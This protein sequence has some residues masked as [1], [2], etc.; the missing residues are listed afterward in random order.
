MTPGKYLTVGGIDVNKMLFLLERP[1]V[2]DLVVADLARWK[3]WSVQPRLMELYGAEGYDIPSIKR[4]IIRYMIAST[5]D[6]AAGGGDEKPA[7]HVAQGAKYL[8]QLR[9]KDAKMVNESERLFFLQ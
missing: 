3:D 1:E 4:A 5:K 7:K 9:D 8:Q 2:T 6:V